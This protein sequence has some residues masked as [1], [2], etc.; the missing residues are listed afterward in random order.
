MKCTYSHLSWTRSTKI[1]RLYSGKKRP[2]AAVVAAAERCCKKRSRDKSFA[3]VIGVP[4]GPRGGRLDEEAEEEKEES[5]CKPPPFFPQSSRRIA[6]F[7][8]R[9]RA[10]L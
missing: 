4:A 2:A 1:L 8:I 9:K 5:R 7:W 3:K 6:S 10:R